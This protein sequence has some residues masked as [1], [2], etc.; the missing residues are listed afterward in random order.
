MVWF[1]SGE[2]NYPAL[3]A[4]TGLLRQYIHVL[5]RK[6]GDPSPRPFGLI[7]HGLRC[8]APRTVPSSMNP[9]IP[10][11]HRRDRSLK[12]AFGANACSG[13][14]GGM[15][16]KRGPRKA[17]RRRAGKARRGARTMRARSLVYTDVHSANLRSAFAHPQG[18]MPGGRAFR[19][20]L[21]LVTLFAQAK[22]VTRSAVGRVEALLLI[23]ARHWIPV[24]AGMTRKE[25]GKY[26]ARPTPSGS[27]ASDGES[28]R[29]I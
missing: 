18:R 7:R 1:A 4:R 22:R 23:R 29:R 28:Y 5:L 14:C 19:G 27:L 11:L 3:L 26:P 13:F 10:A 8:S 12:R 24:F 17:R 9:C 20:V 2:P 16:P 6:R 21:S 25:Q 15:P